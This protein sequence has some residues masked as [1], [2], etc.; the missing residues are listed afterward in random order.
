MKR[1][2]LD[3]AFPETPQAFSERIDQT[4]RRIKEEKPVK[5]ITLKAV[6]VAALITLLAAGAAYALVSL[7][8]EWYFNTRFTAYQE[9]EPEKH[10]AIMD[11]LITDIIQENTGDAAK[12]VDIQVQDASWAKEQKVLTLSYAAILQNPDEYEMYA[13][14]ELDQ[15]GSWTPQLD[16]DDPDSRTEHWLFTHHGYGIPKDV[17]KDPAKRLLL[18][19]PM[20][21]VYIGQTDVAMPIWMSDILTSP[22]GPVI[23]LQEFDLKQ[24]ED[25]EI[26]KDYEGRTEPVGWSKA[27][28]GDYQQYLKDEET[29]LLKRAADMRAAITA[30]TDK[31]GFLH[32][33]MPYELWFYDLEKNDLDR[34]ITGEITFK[35][36]SPE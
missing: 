12:L 20:R 36:K 2:D 30:N 3:R 10:K 14:W 19:D 23:C 5:K 11:N 16:P 28:G 22:D 7:G 35:V 13:L 9:H 34:S 21:E 6:L 27:E 33:R 25:A 8:Q 32:L 29:R 24:L 1:N 4:L 18:I 31:E 17:M 26:R 15:D